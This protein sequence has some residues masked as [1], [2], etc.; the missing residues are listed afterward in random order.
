[1]ARKAFEE[2]ASKEEMQCAAEAIK[3]LRAESEMV[4]IG[5]K[6]IRKRRDAARYT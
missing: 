2:V 3:K 5:D 6:E 1:M 4:W